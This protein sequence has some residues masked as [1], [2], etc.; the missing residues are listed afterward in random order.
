MNQSLNPMNQ[1]EFE[2]KTCNRH[3]RGG[4]ACEH[5]KIGFGFAYDWSRKWCEMFLPIAKRSLKD[6][7]LC[8]RVVFL[9]RQETLLQ[10][11]SL[12]LGV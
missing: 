12:Y 5:V 6:G 2:A 4:N 9:L 8:R 1:S 3:K 10:V 7:G 11:V